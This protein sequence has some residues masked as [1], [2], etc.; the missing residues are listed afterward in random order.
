MFL[1]QLSIIQSANKSVL[2]EFFDLLLRSQISSTGY[3]RGLVDIS[4]TLSSRIFSK[5]FFYIRHLHS[6]VSDSSETYKDKCV[7]TCNYFPL[8][9]CLLRAQYISNIVIILSKKLK[10]VT[11]G[12]VIVYIIIQPL[13]VQNTGNRNLCAAYQRFVPIR[14]SFL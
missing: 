8:Y 6:L 10:L 13:S 2:V 12:D 9:L 4:L 5:N 14:S 7:F 3:N 1:E 11:F